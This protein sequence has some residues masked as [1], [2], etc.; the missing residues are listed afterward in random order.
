MVWKF[1]S[2]DLCI[3]PLKT[4]RCMQNKIREKIIRNLVVHT[5]CIKNVHSFKMSIKLKI[6]Q[7][8]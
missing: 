7:N 2:K 6:L 5:G 4:R 1:N 3:V 8:L